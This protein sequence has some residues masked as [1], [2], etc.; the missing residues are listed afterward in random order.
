MILACGPYIGSWETEIVMFQPFVK[1]LIKVLQP[2][3]V[4]V[5]SH[6]NR[7]FIYPENVVFLP[8][9]ENLTRNEFGQNRTVHEDISSKDYGIILKKFRQDILLEYKGKDLF[10]YGLTYNKFSWIQEYKR[11]IEPIPAKTVKKSKILFIPSDI[12]KSSKLEKI[13][14]I[15]SSSYKEIVV[16]GDMKTYLP[17]YNIL[18]RDPKYFQNVYQNMIDYIQV[19]NGVICPSGVWTFLADL[20]NIPC[21][22]WGKYYYPSINRCINIVN[23]GDIPAEFI[24][25]SII[26]W[27]ERNHLSQK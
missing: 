17:E 2:E 22:S 19:A 20:Y 25:E 6:K 4:F 5:S 14:E 9:Y 7:R 24:G 21:F 23:N 18:L 13:Y 12:E 3:K 1:W 11:I 8:V 16:V 15:I 10:Y 26:Q 27:V